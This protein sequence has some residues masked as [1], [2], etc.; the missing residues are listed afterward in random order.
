MNSGMRASCTLAR[1]HTRTVSRSR[2]RSLSLARSL[3]IS[4]SVTLSL[5]HSHCARAHT[6][7]QQHTLRHTHYAQVVEEA[8]RVQTK[9][10]GAMDRASKMVNDMEIMGAEA[11]LQLAAQSEQIKTTHSDVSAINAGLDTAD[12][13]VRDIGRRLATDKLIVCM[14]L[15]LICMVVGIIVLNVLGYNPA[16]GLMSIDCNLDFTKVCLRVCPCV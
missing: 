15:V 6:H 14:M 1:A 8:K 2:S 12:K 4:L 11:N 10:A 5:S 9:T 16:A 3:S 13:I 7:T